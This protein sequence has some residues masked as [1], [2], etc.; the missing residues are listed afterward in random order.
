MD[1]KRKDGPAGHN[2][3]K[4]KRQKL[5]VSLV[6]GSSSGLSSVNEGDSDSDASL[7]IFDIGSEGKPSQQP[8]QPAQS[9]KRPAAPS[10]SN[11]LPFSGP[12]TPQPHNAPSS[13]PDKFKTSQ[14]GVGMS[15]TVLPS[16]AANP[17]QG[18]SLFS[19][20][21]DSSP[22]VS[23][24]KLQQRHAE[25]LQA[26]AAVQ[27]Q[28]DEAY[29]SQQVKAEEIEDESLDALAAG[30]PIDVN[31]LST[32][33]HGAGIEGGGAAAQ[34]KERPAV[35][36]ERERIIVFHTVSNSESPLTPATL[37]ILTGLKNIFMKQLPKMPREYIARL[38][39]DREH[40]SMAIV[41][42]GYQVV[43]GITYR[44]FAQRGF[45]E[46]VFCAITGTEQV[47]VSDSFSSHILA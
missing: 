40:W 33:G 12:N 44:P 37:I 9:G 36:E 21:A 27:H 28:E 41:K 47:R 4:H 5:D 17:P 46:I 14:K 43:G 16:A 23:L 22:E 45:A 6:D 15:R 31:A 2:G 39:F 34:E 8:S 7:R 25:A 29:L 13:S 11:K 38:V 30:M 32:N 19:R 10:T 42:R 1:H 24:S 18:S 20:A 26:E 3:S 35:T